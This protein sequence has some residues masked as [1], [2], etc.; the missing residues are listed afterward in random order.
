MNITVHD[1]YWFLIRV[2]KTSWSIHDVT[3]P[4]IESEPWY[5]MRSGINHG[6]YEAEI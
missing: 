3:L 4:I 1:S 5:I 2:H 6:Q